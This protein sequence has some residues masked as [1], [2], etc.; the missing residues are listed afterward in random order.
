MDGVTATVLTVADPHHGGDNQ[1]TIV[2]T[3]EED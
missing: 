2:F 3:T 1:A